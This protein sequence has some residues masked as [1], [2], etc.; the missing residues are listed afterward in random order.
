MSQPACVEVFL[1]VVKVQKA[2][3][4]DPTVSY[5]LSQTLLA[6]QEAKEVEEL[7]AK[8]AGK[9]QWLMTHI[10]QLQGRPDLHDELSRLEMGGI[11]WIMI[12]REVVKKKGEE[13]EGGSESFRNLP[14]AA[15]CLGVA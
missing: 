1:R 6:E 13:E 12:K 9:E 7:E 4:D 15:R 2:A 5:L 14:P 11:G 3:H 8:L 10:E